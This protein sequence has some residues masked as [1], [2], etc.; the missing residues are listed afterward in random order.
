MI[1]IS[2]TTFKSPFF[3]I[4][5]VFRQLFYFLT[6]LKTSPFI[7]SFSSHIQKASRSLSRATLGYLPIPKLTVWY[8]YYA[9]SEA[10][11]ASQ[12]LF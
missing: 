2:K 5:R 4:F 10:I 1:T 12:R 9:C 3:G 11:L 8:Q 7:Y 6:A